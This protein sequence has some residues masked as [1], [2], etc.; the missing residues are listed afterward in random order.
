MPLTL[1]NLPW[2]FLAASF[3]SRSVIAAIYDDFSDLPAN[4]Y[5]Y[6][7]VGGTSFPNMV[8]CILRA[9]IGGTAGNV[10]ANRLTEIPSLRVLVLEAGIS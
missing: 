9:R 10:I 2:A 4:T 7:I 5:D 8:L 3:F 6:V 1:G